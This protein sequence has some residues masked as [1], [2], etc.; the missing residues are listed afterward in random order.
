TDIVGARV[1][2]SL[3]FTASE[4]VIA[5]A[6]ISGSLDSIEDIEFVTGAA[7]QNRTS[8]RWEGA[9]MGI[10]DGER[11]GPLGALSTQSPCLA[12][13]SIDTG[14]QLVDR[15]CASAP[16]GIEETFV[17]A[18]APTGSMDPEATAERDIPWLN[19]LRLGE[20][21][22]FFT[23]LGDTDG[24]RFEF[25]F[26]GLQSTA[27]NSGDRDGILTHDISFDVTGGNLYNATG[28]GNV[29]T[30]GVDNEIVIL[31]HQA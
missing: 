23:S 4:P 19:R 7:K 25:Q 17:S 29:G 15:I 9:A 1:N 26:P 2:L 14:L 8:P 31:Y 30:E 6:T 28:G 18:K 16:N 3:A 13:F 5:T 21:A 22:S 12:T 27:A 24:N 10:R 11:A 20:L